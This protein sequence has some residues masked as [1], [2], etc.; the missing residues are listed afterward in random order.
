MLEKQAV[1]HTSADIGSTHTQQK[2]ITSRFG[3]SNKAETIRWSEKKAL[4]RNTGKRGLVA[5][6]RYGG[7]TKGSCDYGSSTTSG[8]TPRNTLRTHD[9]KHTRMPCRVSDR[10]IQTRSRHGLSQWVSLTLYH[11]FTIDEG[12]KLDCSATHAIHTKNGITCSPC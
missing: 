6:A 5:H 10:K 7:T 4:K 3:W 11:V 1:R 9:E 2:D 12:K 8:Q